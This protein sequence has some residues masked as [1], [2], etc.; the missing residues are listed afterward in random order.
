MALHPFS[1]MA[2]Y[3]LLGAVN[4][5]RKDLKAGATMKEPDYLAAIV[6]KFPPLMNTMWGNAKYGGCYIHQKPYVTTVAGDTCEAGDLLVLCRK[7]VDGKT[8]INA[9]LFQLK[10]PMHL[11][12]SIRPDNKIQLDLYTQWRSFSMGRTFDLAKSLDIQPKAATPGAQYMFINGYP[13]HYY[14]DPDF[15]GCYVGSPVVFAHAIPEPEMY[16]RG[17]CSFG[18]FLWNFIHWQTGRPIAPEKDQAND[19]WSRFIWELIERTQNAK[20][21]NVNVG[22]QKKHGIS[23]QQGDFFHFMTTDDCINDLPQKYYASREM[24][25]ETEPP[26]TDENNYNES[27]GAVSILMIDMAEE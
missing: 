23:R 10:K 4:S 24:D 13:E 26:V 21:S 12:H 7:T 25:G 6:T 20:I 15:D 17:D 5:I 14:Y 22:I 9:A 18:R 27:D 1:T 8:R 11:Y 19:D 3:M 16:F 2:N